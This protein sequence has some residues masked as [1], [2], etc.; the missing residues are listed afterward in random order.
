MG[1]FTRINAGQPAERT[2]E[3]LDAIRLTPAH[4]GFTLIE[5]I[6]RVVPFRNILISGIDVQDHGPGTGTHLLSDFPPDY[7]AEYYA[8]RLG[9]IDPLFAMLRQGRPVSRDSE[10]FATATARRNGRAVLDLL[11]RHDIVE[12]TIIL[13]AHSGKVLGSVAVIS[14][15]PL[16]ED[17]CALLKHFALSLHAEVSAPALDALNTA[18]RLTRGEL[19]CL[20]RAAGGLTSEEIGRV[21][22][23]SVE[24]VNTYLKSAT[25]KLGANNRTQAVVEALRRQLIT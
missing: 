8:G 21:E 10:A 22:D 7:V 13:V 18:L 4:D 3:A 2:R 6:K 12:R 1:S 16:S 14:D 9:D 5:A 25:R 23:Y 15:A 24:T 11:R 20:E 17:H 19:R